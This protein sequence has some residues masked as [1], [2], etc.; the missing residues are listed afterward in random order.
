MAFYGVT[1][2]STE[3]EL[4]KQLTI[5][6]Q[7]A[8]FSDD[9][10]YKISC[11]FSG[12]KSWI[13][14]A[15]GG[16]TRGSWF[17][18]IDLAESIVDSDRATATIIVERVT[19]NSRQEVYDSTST[20]ITLVV[21]QNA[22]TLPAAAMSVSP[23]NSETSIFP[24][25]YLRGQT[26]VKADFTDSVGKYGA[27][28]RSYSVTVCGVSRNSTDTEV[29]SDYV[30]LSGTITVKGTVTDSRGFSSTITQDIDVLAYQ[31]PAPVPYTNENKVIC[32]R[33]TEE[34]TISTQGKNLLIKSGIEYSDI[35]LGEVRN[36]CKLE[37]RYK[38]DSEEWPEDA[39]ASWVEL[40]PESEDSTLYNV[41]AEGVELDLKTLYTVQLRATDS[42]GGQKV[43]TIRISAMSTPLHLKAGGKSVG[44]GMYASN[45]EERLDVG[46]NLHLHGRFEVEQEPIEAVWEVGESISVGYF[47]NHYLFVA[48]LDDSYDT[49][50]LLL[51]N[52]NLATGSLGSSVIEAEYYPETQLLKLISCD[53]S[54]P[55]IKK[56]IPIL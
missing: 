16:S 13:F 39:T 40:T 12:Q 49:P 31:K 53:F 22:E 48:V 55:T 19:A 20:T 42:L 4:G 52:G 38:A 15:D 54:T 44:I 17:P 7:N 29:V 6:L 32:A 46:W 26:K 27:Q 5:T 10:F 35:S 43:A 21:P 33:A 28:I 8:S 51:R 37:Y 23:V 18:P 30:S 14:N 1:F 45:E 34:G 50:I 11:S 41:I 3:V 25:L 36:E 56:L 47:L 2:S 9:W 24:D